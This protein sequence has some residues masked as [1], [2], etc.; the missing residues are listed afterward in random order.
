MPA[1]YDRWYVLGGRVYGYLC[2]IR[3]EIIFQHLLKKETRYPML[4]AESTERQSTRKDT[5]GD[6]DGIGV[7]KIE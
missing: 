3:T 7:L 4:N 1:S 5:H 6:Y 2:Y